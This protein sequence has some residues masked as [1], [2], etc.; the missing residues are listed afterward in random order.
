MI[1]DIDYGKVGESISASYAQVA[2]RYRCD[3]EIEVTT[4]NHAH[5]RNILGAISSS[6]G[7]PISVLD[8]G[9]GTGRYFYCLKNVKCLTGID[10]SQE[11]LRI[12]GSPVRQE[13]IT[14]GTIELN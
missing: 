2:A 8:A 7:R 13:E 9:C 6:F 5:L 11:M 1:T 4:E 12:A 14:A 3:D 10:I